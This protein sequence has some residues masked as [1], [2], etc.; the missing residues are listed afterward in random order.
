MALFKI[1]RGGYQNK[2]ET[3]TDGWAYFTPDNRGFYIDVVDNNVG[4]F[5]YN[6]RIQINEKV[7]K[8]TDTLT[9]SNW[10]SNTYSLSIDSRFSS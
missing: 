6:N 8:T 3:L 1:L 4:G 2:P 7:V 9:A 10:T 5:S